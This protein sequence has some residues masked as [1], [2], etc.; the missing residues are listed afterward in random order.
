MALVMAIY[1]NPL[2]TTP[3]PLTNNR[4]IC[5]NII[6]SSIIIIINNQGIIIMN[7][8]NSSRRSARYIDNK[9]LTTYHLLSII[10]NFQ[11]YSGDII[12]SN[13]VTGDF[14]KYHLSFY[15]HQAYNHIQYQKSRG[16]KEASTYF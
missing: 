10:S 5:S 1:C 15:F 9:V 7:K 8:L 2:N 3:S 16:D 14:H 11:G 13:D 6:Q 4:N 12:S